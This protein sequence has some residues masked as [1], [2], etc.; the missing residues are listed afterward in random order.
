MTPSNDIA[1]VPTA[2]PDGLRRKA[3]VVLAIGVV[4]VAAAGIL[5][6]VRFMA[7]WLVLF[8]FVLTV[9]LGCLFV[10]ALEYTVNARWSVPFRRVSE[11]LAALVPVSLVLAVPVLIGMHHL[12]E[13]T[14]VEVVA[15]DPVLAGKA[16]YLNVPFFVGRLAAYYLVWL[17]FYR[18]FVG[19]SLRQD[20]TGDERMTRRFIRL[21]PPFMILFAFTVSFA[22]IDLLMSLSPHWFSS[23]FGPTI[24]VS[25]VVG[26]LALTTLAAVLL[27][28]NGMLPDRVGPDHF[29][30]LGALLFGLNTLRA[31]MAYSQFLLIWYS[32]LPAEWVWY[33]VRQEGGWY[34][35]S[36]SMIVIQF[37]VPFIAL[38]S[39][40]AKMDLSRL[41]WVSIWVL[42]AYALDLYWIVL[43]SVPHLE[44]GP[45]SWME[46]GFPFLAVGIGLFVWIR[47]ASRGPL[48]AT[49]DP[50]LEAGLA[51]HL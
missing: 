22:A 30:N 40:S 50:R 9:G 28:M 38:L 46:L 41:R 29:Y 16:S 10:V 44:G 6:P 48:L 7:N 27:K 15:A 33:A 3:G 1:Q 12:Y 26:G 51:F 11:H 18:L 2:M 45:F 42:A 47:R 35:V 49:R 5:D 19:G 14:H 43:P 32:N 21:G 36:V 39:R 34:A 17:L 24:A 37:F 25:A 13:W 8:V 20:R 23:I 4:L 31:Y